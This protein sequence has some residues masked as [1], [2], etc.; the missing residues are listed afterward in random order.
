VSQWTLALGVL[1]FAHVAGG[2]G[3]ALPLSSRAEV[4][5]GLT[6]STTL[7]AV[8][9]L[10]SL[11]PR[12]FDSWII[13]TLYAIQFAFPATE[14]RIAVAV[15]LALFTLDILVANRR[16]VWPM[17]AALRSHRRPDLT[18]PQPRHRAAEGT[19]GGKSTKR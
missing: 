8:A 18:E 3:L 12:R 6:V 13:L 16:A 7:M 11:A 9:A 5:L 1:P 2:G 14:V 17:F 19:S 10:C 4:E 15:V